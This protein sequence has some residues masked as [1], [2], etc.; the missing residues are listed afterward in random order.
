MSQA[1][2]VNQGLV[3]AALEI[4]ERRTNTLRELRVALERGDNDLA[5]SIARK[6]CGLNDQKSHRVVEGIH[7]RTSRRR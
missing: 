3:E 2:E 5:L 7:S 6:V 4:A 1:L